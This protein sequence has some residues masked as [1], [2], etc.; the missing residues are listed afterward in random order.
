MIILMYTFLVSQFL[1]ITRKVE[2]FIKNFY[3]SLASVVSCSKMLSLLDQKNII[4]LIH[5]LEKL[6]SCEHS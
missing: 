5:I 1:D 2:D 3:V 4:M 6:F